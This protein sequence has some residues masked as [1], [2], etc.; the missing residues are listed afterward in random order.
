[1]LHAKVN[2]VVLLRFVNEEIFQRIVAV[3]W[4]KRFLADL[5]VNRT[6]R[7]LRLR[8]HAD[9]PISRFASRTKEI[10]DF[11]HELLALIM[12]VLRHLSARRHCQRRF[13][14]AGGVRAIKA[15]QFPRVGRK[16]TALSGGHAPVTQGPYDVH[17]VHSPCQVVVA[18]RG[19]A[20]L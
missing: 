17:A 5:A 8:L 6:C 2:A 18:T 16:L 19:P 12:A 15:R 20:F 13:D 11:G 4:G 1:M 9:E 3:G 10:G 7:V 14:R